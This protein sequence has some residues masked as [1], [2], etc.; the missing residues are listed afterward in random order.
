VCT[1]PDG[2]V[3]LD[4]S[5]LKKW[6]KKIKQYGGE[7]VSLKLIKCFSQL[8]VRKIMLFTTIVLVWIHDDRG[9]QK[10]LLWGC[11]PQKYCMETEKLKVK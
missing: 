9:I 8:N 7:Q 5:I 3:N 10:N 1:A 11:I 2:T 4:Y 6:T